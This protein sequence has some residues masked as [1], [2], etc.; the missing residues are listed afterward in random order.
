MTKK[1]VSPC[2]MRKYK[3]LWEIIQPIPYKEE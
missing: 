3:K 1:Y 2:P